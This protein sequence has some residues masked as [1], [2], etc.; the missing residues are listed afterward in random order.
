MQDGV[1]EPPEVG[2]DNHFVRYRLDP[3]PVIEHA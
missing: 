1:R 3:L 2:I